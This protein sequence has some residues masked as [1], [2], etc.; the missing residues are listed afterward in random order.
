MV[1]R[2]CKDS[3]EIFKRGPLVCFSASHTYDG[4][5]EQIPFK[6]RLPLSG[7]SAAKE[8]AFQPFYDTGVRLEVWLRRP[9]KKTRWERCYTNASGYTDRAAQNHYRWQAH[10]HRS[11]DATARTVGTRR[12]AR[13]NPHGRVRHRNGRNRWQARMGCAQA[14]RIDPCV[15][16]ATFR[17]SGSLLHSSPSLPGS[18]ECLAD[19][20]ARNA[21]R[22]PGG[23]ICTS[24][25]TP[26]IAC[27]RK[28]ATQKATNSVQDR[29]A[30]PCEPA[31]RA[32]KPCASLL[33]DACPRCEVRT[34]SSSA[35]ACQ[36]ISTTARRK[37]FATAAARLREAWAA[38]AGIGG[39]LGIRDPCQDAEK[40]LRNR[41]PRVSRVACN[42]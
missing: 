16:E 3:V 14:E 4:G 6:R 11:G 20:L 32:P 8:I 38:A 7:Y 23:R 12:P 35:D 30:A 15:Q 19:L 28:K 33:A 34:F 37:T 10:C 5:L 25:C 1:Q 39:W 21:Q 24:D 29:E 9:P 17:A 2:H 31:L 42:R 13:N 27:S 41:C 40:A 18:R 36:T 26:R 22:I